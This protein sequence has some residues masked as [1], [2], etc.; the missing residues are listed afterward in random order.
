MVQWDLV[1]SVT[2]VTGTF[3]F[4]SAAAMAEPKSTCFT[5]PPFFQFLSS[6]AWAD[7]M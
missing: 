1:L 7:S 5:V 4:V 2:T 3:F 6:S